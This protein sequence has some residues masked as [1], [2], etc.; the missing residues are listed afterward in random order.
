MLHWP[1]DPD[2]R[3]TRVSDMGGGDGANLTHLDMGAHTGTHLDAPRHFVR[4]GA[5]VDE[6]ELSAVAGPA[7]V[8][9]IRDAEVITADELMPRQIGAGERILFKTRNSDR[10]WYREPFSEDFVHLST[11]AAEYLAERRPR[12]VGIDYL[13]IGGYGRNEREVHQALLGSNILVVEGLYLGCV[14]RGDYELICLPVK[15]AG[16]DGAPAR[17]IVRKTG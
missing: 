5:G 13:S 4:E 10:E 3:I 17:A 14:E 15:I 16:G 11:E 9:E 12:M 6:I 1:G 2:V 7:R 8:M